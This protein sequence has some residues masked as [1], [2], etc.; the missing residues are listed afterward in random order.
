MKDDPGN[1][2]VDAPYHTLKI[3][4]E[5]KHLE[6]PIELSKSM[7]TWFKHFS[8]EAGCTASEVDNQQIVLDKTKEA[9]CESFS[10]CEGTLVENDLK[11]FITPLVHRSNETGKSCGRPWLRLMPT[12]N[13]DL[14]IYYRSNAFAASTSD[15]CTQRI[16]KARTRWFKEHPRL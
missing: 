8:E 6:K 9:W 10:G 4:G 11:I 1:V 13:S 7:D 3:Q 14:V 16:P 5:R 15:F 2:Q 12:V